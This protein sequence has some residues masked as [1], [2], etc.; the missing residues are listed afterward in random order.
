MEPSSSDAPPTFCTTAGQCGPR[1]VYLDQ[2]KFVLEFQYNKIVVMPS[3]TVSAL[4]SLRA[5]AWGTYSEGKW[6]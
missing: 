2:L 6:L 3:A 4:I 1:T 5:I